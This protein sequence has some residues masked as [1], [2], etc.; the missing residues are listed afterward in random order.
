MNKSAYTIADQIALLKQRGMI[1]RDETQ[2]YERLK[3]ISYYRLKGYWWDM[4]SDTTRHLF[5]PDVCFEDIL[6]RYDFDR[7]LRRILF[8]GIEQIEIAVRT[9][10][11][12]CLSIAYGGLWYLNPALFNSI[13]KNINGVNKTVHLWVLDELHKEFN[14]SQELFIKDHRIRYQGQPADAWKILEVASMGTL[15]KLYKNLKINLPER[16]IIANEMGVN[17]PH[18]FSGWLESIAYIRNIIAHHS[19]LWSRT[20]VKRPSMQLNNPR[21]AWFTKPIQQGQIDKPFSTISCMTYLC[22]FAG[23]PQDMKREIIELINDYPDVPIYKYGFFNNWRN[24]PIW[25]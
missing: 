22:D 24:E 17:S 3:N 9:R 12:Y 16:S 5:Y 19:R 1:F 21:S 2:A 15:S 10:L 18:V 14:R 11:I 20:M 13:T 4:Q 6:E 25:Q 23:Q 7:K 8:G